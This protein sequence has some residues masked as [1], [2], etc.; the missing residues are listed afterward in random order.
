MDAGAGVEGRVT[1]GTWLWARQSVVAL[2]RTLCSHVIGFA[3]LPEACRRL[4][5][6]GFAASRKPSCVPGPDWPS[7]E[8]RLRE[9]CWP[10]WTG[11]LAVHRGP[12]KH[13]SRHAA[14]LPDRSKQASGRRRVVGSIKRALPAR[15]RCAGERAGRQTGSKGK[16]CWRPIK[17]LT[18]ACL[19]GA[20]TVLAA[21]A[22]GATPCRAAAN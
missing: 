15:G 13:R 17:R 18:R 5:L 14:R 1:A 9:Q 10:P 21:W 16:R 6:S 22:W 11:F 8:A 7:I 3:G 4:R 19:V 2:G 12:T 20:L